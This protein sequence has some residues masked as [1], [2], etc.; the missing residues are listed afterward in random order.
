MKVSNLE[1]ELASDLNALAEKIRDYSRNQKE[2]WR[3]V[4]YLALQADGHGGYSSTY[5]LA[6][7][8]GYWEA[9]ESVYVDLENGE[10]IQY[11]YAPWEKQ[12]EAS[13]IKIASLISSNFGRLNATAVIS[14]LRVTG[15]GKDSSCVPIGFKTVRKWR[16]SLMEEYG[17]KKI[18]SRKRNMNRLESREG[19][20]RVWDKAFKI[21]ENKK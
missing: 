14:D 15:N 10:L 2:L 9:G 16:E 12:V 4:P 21:A 18:Y 11:P 8:H 17:I 1:K 19:L 7:I 5:Q 3:K 6:Y 13:N 20:S